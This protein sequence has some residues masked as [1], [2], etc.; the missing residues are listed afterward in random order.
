LAN[1]KKKTPRNSNK[2]DKFK[3]DIV[4]IAL[5]VIFT[6]LAVLF[7]YFMP[8]SSQTNNVAV[9]NAES[10]SAEELDFWYELSILPENRE[11]ITKQE[12]LSSS[13]IPQQVLVQQ[14]ADKGISVNDDDVE[15][16][17][18][19]HLINNG[20]TLD[21]FRGE[22]TARGATIDD[23]MKAFE[24]RATVIKLLGEEGIY[25]N[26]QEFQDYLGSL[27]EKADIEIFEAEIGKPT[28]K[29]FKDNGNEACGRELILYVASTCETCNESI[30]IF[31]EHSDV[32]DAEAFVWSLDTGDNLLT[33]EK[34]NGVPKREVEVFKG[35][36]LNNKIPAVVLGCKYWMVGGLNKNNEA[37]FSSIINYLE[38]A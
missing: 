9:V 27:M 14:S 37:E 22:L 28:L 8:Y 17:I 32:A 3:K 26:S 25:E 33:S 4:K 13:L 29:Y 20:I 30:D 36:N 15:K 7:F 24:V 35:N 18:G 1:K 34:E 12:F 31:T 11:Q 5:F 2:K 10:I 6:V 21:E 19:Q 23:I 38:G 16:L